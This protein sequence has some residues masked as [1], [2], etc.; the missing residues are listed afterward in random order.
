MILPVVARAKRVVFFGL[1]FAIL[2]WP[3]GACAKDMSE[4]LVHAFDGDD[5]AWPYAGLI[6]D[7]TGNLYGTTSEGGAHGKGTVFK[8]AT[9]GTE[10]ALYSFDSH[11][12]DGI[13]SHAG[14]VRDDAGSL[15]GT[16]PYGGSS[17]GVCYLEG[18]GVVFEVTP[19]GNETVLY[20]FTAG[21]DGDSPRAGLIRDKDGNLYGTTRSQS[22]SS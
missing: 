19:K 21:G 11:Q 3:D 10:K 15:Y 22:R 20:A 1:G 17:A 5:G 16:T 13:N 14:L 12:G 18:C 7:K 9:N 8:L 4:V 6:A 2:A